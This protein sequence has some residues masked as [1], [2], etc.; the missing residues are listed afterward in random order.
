MTVSPTLSQDAG[1]ISV[2]AE[3]PE[4][5]AQTIL[6]WRQAQG[7]E[8]TPANLSCHITVLIAPDT[9]SP[10]P[11]L[12]DALAGT[13]PIAV[14]LGAP[15]SFAPL[16]PVT[17]LPLVSGAQEFDALHS[18]SVQAL[19]GSA[20]PFPYAP[21]LTLANQLPAEAL[22]ASLRDFGN[23]PQEL[24]AFSVNTLRVYRYRAQTWE[25]LGTISLGG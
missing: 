23:L 20:S 24:T 13:A 8:P 25:Y 22:E 12:S 11:V 14:E 18:L 16:T 10:L 4:A 2:L 5:L 15:A 17:Y 9:D 21:H 7:A 1:Y 19:G 6:D 3:V